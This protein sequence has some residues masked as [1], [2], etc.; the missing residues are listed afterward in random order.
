MGALLESGDSSNRRNRRRIDDRAL[1]SRNQVRPGSASD[2]VDDVEFV[3]KGE[4]PV[5]NGELI[6]APKTGR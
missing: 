3:A 6:K 5:F 1:P 4:L 2:Q